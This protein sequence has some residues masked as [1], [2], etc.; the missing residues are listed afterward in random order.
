[1]IVGGSEDPAAIGLK[2]CGVS[3]GRDID[4][5]TGNLALG[6]GCAAIVP[7]RGE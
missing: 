1:M 5:Q 7:A 4:P 2:P 3:C 6:P